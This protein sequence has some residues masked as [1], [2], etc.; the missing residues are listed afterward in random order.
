VKSN[1]RLNNTLVPK[2]RILTFDEEHHKYSDDIHTPYT[3]CTTVIGK[4]YK[5]FDDDKMDIAKACEKIGKNPNHPKYPKYKGMT[6]KQ[7]LMSWDKTRDDACEK[8]TKKHNFLETA[9]KS[10]NGYNRSATGFINGRIYTIDDIIVGHN[11]GRLSLNF[12]VK[13]GIA[14]KYPTIYKFIQEFTTRGFRIYAEIGTYDAGFGVS[15]LVDILFVKGREFFILDWKTNRAPIRF[16]AGYYAKDNNNR[17]LLDQFITQDKWMLDPISH[18]PDSVGTHYTLQLS[19]YDYL[20]ETFGLTCLGNILCHI[21]T[22]ESDT[23]DFAKDEKE[24]VN[25]IPIKYMKAEAEALLTDHARKSI[26]PKNLFS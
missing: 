9:V 2:G 24:E 22:I 3:S 23:L 13:T 7:I 6:A 25:F 11:Y 20:I 17:L 4:Y 10:A 12:F 15:G 19:I 18:M 1:S 14:D 26:T 8:G 5:H 21:R 16:E